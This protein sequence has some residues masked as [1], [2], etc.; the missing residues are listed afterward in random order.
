MEGTDGSCQKA[1]SARP[2]QYSSLMSDR[3]YQH[4][5]TTRQTETSL[6]DSCALSVILSVDNTCNEI[7]LLVWML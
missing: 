2:L 4:Q 3:N 6:D 7:G 5:T 1:A